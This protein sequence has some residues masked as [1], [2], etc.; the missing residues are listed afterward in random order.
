[1]QNLCD[2]LELLATGTINHNSNI[3]DF[4]LSAISEDFLIDY[5]ELE[6]LEDFAEHELVLEE[7]NRIWQ[8]YEY[9][10]T[11]TNEQLQKQAESYR[12]LNVQ[13]IPEHWNFQES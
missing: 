13:G 4:I 12:K 5:D 1:M 6:S 9:I 8:D 7:I 3:D 2:Y 11:C 10:Q